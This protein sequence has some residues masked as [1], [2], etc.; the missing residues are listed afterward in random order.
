MFRIL[1]DPSSGSRELCLTEIT[2][3][4]SQIYCHVL[5]QCWAV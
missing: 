3:S 1:R 2:C 4:D 5:G